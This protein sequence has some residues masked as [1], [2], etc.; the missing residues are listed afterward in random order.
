MKL[1]QKPAA[2]ARKTIKYPV[3]TTINLAQRES[4]SQ[5][6]ATLAIGIALI[7]VL[8][9]CVAKFGV[10][11]QLARQREAEQAY[12]TVHAQYVQMQQAIENYPAVEQEYRTYSR[13]WMQQDAT[14]SF[15]SVE[16]V[17]VLD[18]LEQYLM[19]YGTVNSVAMQKDTVVVSMSGMNLEQISAMFERLQKQPIVA[20]A[21]LN[22]ASTAQNAQA[23][24]LDFSVTITLQP[25]KEAEA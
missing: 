21:S 1:E 24:D 23:S 8:S 18:L 5:N 11:D 7:A 16:R 12:N 10:I 3:K 4:R 13:S 6:V 17:D 20:G 19:P 14:G 25:E 22:L 9:F 15:V 2:K